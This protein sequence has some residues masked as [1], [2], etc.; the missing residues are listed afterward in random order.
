MKDK[1]KEF[2]H[3]MNNVSFAELTRQIPDSAGQRIMF[4]Q[5]DSLVIWEGVSHEF[6]EAVE[7]LLAEGAIVLKPCSPM[8]YVADR[9]TLGG[10]PVADRVRKYAEPHWLPV[11]LCRT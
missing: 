8:V 5:N 11:V 7:Q 3:R 10:L 2:V 9:L 6:A 4:T 1:I